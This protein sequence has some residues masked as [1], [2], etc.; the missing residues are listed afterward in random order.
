M[1]KRE[2]E[3]SIHQIFHKDIPAE[4]RDGVR[5]HL[6]GNIEFPGEARHCIT[7]VYVVGLILE[8]ATGNDAEAKAA[9]D[10]VVG[11]ISERFGEGK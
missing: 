2:I 9:V 3:K 10:A 8:K 7:L 5:L 11:L 1:L 4:T 6:Y